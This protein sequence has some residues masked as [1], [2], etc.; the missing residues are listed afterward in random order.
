MKTSLLHNT[1]RRLVML[2]FAAILALSAV[3]APVLADNLAG[4]GLTPHAYAC[5][6]AGGTC[7]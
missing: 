2:A 3:Y 4:T 1:R 7:G 5:Q 6:P